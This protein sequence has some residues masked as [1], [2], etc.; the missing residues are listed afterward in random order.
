MPEVSIVDDLLAPLEYI[1]INYKGKN[2]FSVCTMVPGLLR[3]I[4]KVTG[5]DIFE[6]DMRWDIT[7]DNRDFFA[8]WWGKRGED[9][10]TTTRP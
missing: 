8:V 5:Q 2:P 9:S 10:W 6:S 1:T 7:A 3:D 4:M